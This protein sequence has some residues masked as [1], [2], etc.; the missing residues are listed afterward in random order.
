MSRIRNKNN[1][2]NNKNNNNINDTHVATP[3]HLPSP[4]VPSSDLWDLVVDMDWPRVIQHVQEYPHDAE[5]VDGHYDESVLYLCCQHNPPLE[6]VQAIRRAYPP[7]VAIR[8]SRDHRELPLHIACR[9]QMSVEILT[10]LVQEDPAT[11]V[12]HN[13]IGRTPIM[14]LWEARRRQ[15]AWRDQQQYQQRQQEQEDNNTDQGDDAH[16]AII[17]AFEDDGGFWEKMMVLLRAVARHRQNQSLGLGPSYVSPTRVTARPADQSPLEGFQLLTNTQIRDHFVVHAAVSLSS[18]G[19][20]IQVLRYVIQRFPTQVHTRDC[21]GK[22]PLHIAVGPAPFHASMRR[23]Y[24]PREQEFVTALINAYPEAAQLPICG[25]S[26]TNTPSLELGD[27]HCPLMAALHNRHVWA[28]GVKNLVDAA[29]GTMLLRDPVTKLYPFQLAAIP[30]G[31]TTTST[32]DLDTIYELL[33][34]QPQVMNLLDFSTRTETRRLVSNENIL[35]ATVIAALVGVIAH[36][37][38]VVVR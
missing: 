13:R 3:R 16:T 6:A 37:V 21:D 27:Y 9:Y 20:P 25:V 2:N 26:R 29:P 5:Y 14:E 32:V 15:Q 10:E 12:V 8:N 17:V 11:T 19:C 23:Q 4:D 31:D 18:Y 7:A 1:K 30:S 33:R 24:L 38:V 36:I 22:L 35:S 28:G 34:A